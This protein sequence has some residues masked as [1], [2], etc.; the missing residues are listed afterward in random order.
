MARLERD[1]EAARA[2]VDDLLRRLSDPEIYDRPEEVHALATAHEA[3]AQRAA[4]LLTR[5][6]TAVDALE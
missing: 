5:W 6:E 4:A 3:A 2:E 1:Y